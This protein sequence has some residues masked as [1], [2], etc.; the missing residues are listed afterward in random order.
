MCPYNEFSVPGVGIYGLYY[1]FDRLICNIDSAMSFDKQVSET[2]KACFFVFFH[3]R[4]MR[5]D[6]ATLTT[7]TSKTIA[8]T[9]VGS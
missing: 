6:R 2:C 9:I 8:A 7:E 1:R 3:I 5:H 4:A